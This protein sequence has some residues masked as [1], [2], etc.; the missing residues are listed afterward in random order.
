MVLLSKEIRHEVKLVFVL[1]G[2]VVDG[3]VVVEQMKVGAFIQL[4]HAEEVRH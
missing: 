2:H 1:C 4:Q 3:Q